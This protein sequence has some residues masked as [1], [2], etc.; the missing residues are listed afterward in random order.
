MKRVEV[1]GVPFAHLLWSRLLELWELQRRPDARRD[2]HVSPRE[3]GHPRRAKE[4]DSGDA[5][6][7]EPEAGLEQVR[8]RGVRLRLAKGVDGREGVPVLQ[9]V[10]DQALPVRHGGALAPLH[11]ERRVLEAARDDAHV[12]PLRHPARQVLPRRGLEPARDVTE[13]LEESRPLAQVLSYHEGGTPPRCAGRVAHPRRED[14]LLLRRWRGQVVECPIPHAVAHEA[15]R[16]DAVRVEHEEVPLRFH[17]VEGAAQLAAG[18]VASHVELVDQPHEPRPPT[19]R[20]AE[21]EIDDQP[22]ECEAG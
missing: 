5:E 20:D 14:R 4:H 7:V 13:H 21:V 19:H 16:E 9:R 11:V 17:G 3:E 15:D 22:N 2:R 12:A 1:S 18:V 8:E 6:P 10:L